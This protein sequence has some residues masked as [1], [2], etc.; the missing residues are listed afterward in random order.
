VNRLID[1]SVLVDHLRGDRRAVDL[2]LGLA[3]SGDELWSVTVVRTEVLA[4]VRRGEERQT[5]RLL[6]L[7]R[8]HDVTVEVADRA[9]A[10]A[11]AYARARSG[12]DTV[13]YLL[14]A[15]TGSLAQTS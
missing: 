7:L 3:R 12:I 4:G 6:D 11:R 14:A 1:T 13:D 15:V 2:L 8:W 5:H 9:G 10:L